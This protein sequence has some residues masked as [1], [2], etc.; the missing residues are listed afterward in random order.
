MIDVALSSD[1][2]IVDRLLG[3]PRVET[4]RAGLDRLSW[5]QGAWRRQITVGDTSADLFGLAELMDNNPMVCAD[6]VSVPDPGQ[7]LA[8]IALA[9]VLE[10]GLA[11]ETPRLIV[12]FDADFT[13]ID[14]ALARVGY[15]LGIDGRVEHL[16]LGSVRAATAMVEVATPDDVSDV[17]SVYEERFGRSFY[18]RRD[19]TSVWD[20]ALVAGQPHAVFRLTLAVDHPA[21]LLTVRVLADRDG[22]AG[23]DQLI[24]AMNVMCGFEESLGLR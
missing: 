21:S 4:A 11:V 16:D 22:K 3:H 7:T 24:H 15:P 9:P 5:T 2:R 23:G 8:L 12:N 13:T 6:H 20:P 14:T 1:P 19:Q 18:V 17:E 10:A